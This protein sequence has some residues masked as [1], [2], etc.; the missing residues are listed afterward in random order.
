[1]QNTWSDRVRSG[2]MV[3]SGRIGSHRVRV[4]HIGSDRVPL[5]PIGPVRSNMKPTQL[6]HTTADSAKATQLRNHSQLIRRSDDVKS[7]RSHSYPHLPIPGLAFT[8]AGA[9]L[10]G[11]DCPLPKLVDGGEGFMGLPAGCPGLMPKLVS[12]RPPGAGPRTSTM[13]SSN[14]SATRSVQG[15]SVGKEW[16]GAGLRG[17]VRGGLI[18]VELPTSGAGHWPGEGDRREPLGITCAGAAW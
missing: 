9:F 8:R 5:G 14:L 16:D 7:G 11:F 15:R 17:E 10:P 18:W 4:G 6:H 1:M 13:S 2:P 3:R 12:F